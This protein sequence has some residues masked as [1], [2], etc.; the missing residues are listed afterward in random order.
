MINVILFDM[1]NVILPVDGDR[2]ARKLARYSPQTPQ[3]I[4]EAF[5]DN[6]ITDRFEQG[7]MSPKEFF[8]L[9]TRTAEIQGLSYEDF[10]NMFNDIF[11]EDHQVIELV[12]NL[13]KTYKLGLIS[14]TNPLHVP[15]VLKKF[16]VLS[17]FDKLWMS[18][19]VGIRKPDPG[20]FQM[21][22]T[23]FGVP[24]SAAVFIDDILAHVDAARKLGLHGIHFQNFDQLAQNLKDLGVTI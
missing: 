18:S 8:E 13:K 15:Y 3:K 21:A 2:L 1:G 23:H 14:N 24:P 7:K 17:T 6:R 22:L 16:P 19:E 11:E 9:V 4:L 5:W 12:K 20:L 10:I